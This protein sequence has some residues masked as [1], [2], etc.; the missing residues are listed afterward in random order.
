MGQTEDELLLF[1]EYTSEQESIEGVLLW[2]GAKPGDRET[3]LDMLRPVEKIL[4]QVVGVNLQGPGQKAGV[5]ATVHPGLRL[6]PVQPSP[7]WDAD[8]LAG[9]VRR[10]KWWR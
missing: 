10:T 6:L 2:M 3:L 7:E 4:L 9:I 1:N 8:T 5:T